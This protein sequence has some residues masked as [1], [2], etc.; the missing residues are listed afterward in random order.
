LM[1]LGDSG[2]VVISAVK[3][4]HRKTVSHISDCGPAALW[5]LEMLIR[6]LASQYQTGPEFWGYSDS[7]PSP[8]TK[9]DQIPVFRGINKTTAVP[10]VWS[11]PYNK[12]LESH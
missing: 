7:T 3:A 4:G 1:Y 6:G 2:A 12:N 11:F 10:Q 5:E 9:P 8:Q